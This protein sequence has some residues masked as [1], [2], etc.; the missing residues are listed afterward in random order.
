MESVREVG[1]EGAGSGIPN[2][3]VEE[4]GKKLIS[5]DYS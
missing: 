1:E 5:V 4:V 3:K 2:C